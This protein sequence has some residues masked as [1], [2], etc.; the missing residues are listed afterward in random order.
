MAGKVQLF[1]FDKT[2]TL[3][4]EGLEFYG[5]KPI[6]DVDNV[7]EQRAQKQTPTF[8]VH[9]HDPLS[10][11]RLMQLSIATCHAVT[12]LNDQ[13]IGNPV[14][15]EMF[16]SSKWKLELQSHEKDDY[17]DTLTPPVK[18]AGDNADPVHVL[19]RFEFVHARM[20]MSVA[21]LD[22]HTN[23]VHIFVKGAYEKIKDL[24]NPE[25]VPEDYDETAS[26]LAREGCYVSDFTWIGKRASFWW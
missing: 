2:G 22:T 19:K 7:V 26:S 15:I 25:S 16:R 5:T 1:C 10:M 18:N 11:P 17:V 23:K 14:D 4:R 12:I 21:V 6:T 20:S 3:T 9:Q 13:F 24:S 8:G